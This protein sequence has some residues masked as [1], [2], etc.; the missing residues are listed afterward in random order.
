MPELPRQIHD[1]AGLRTGKVEL[2][3]SAYHELHEKALR[4]RSSPLDR[5]SNSASA[6]GYDRA[7]NGDFATSRKRTGV[8]DITFHA[9]GARKAA[10]CGE[11]DG[12][13][14]SGPALRQGCRHTDRI[15]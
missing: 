10:F 5:N 13:G 11:L 8:P 7:R 4:L 15:I 14:R 2:D 1:S 9:A 12:S 6:A 3:Q